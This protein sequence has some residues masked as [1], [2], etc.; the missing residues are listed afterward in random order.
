MADKD[1][2]AEKLK[3]AA[4]KQGVPAVPDTELPEDPSEAKKQLREQKNQL[5]KDEKARKKEARLRAKSISKQEAEISEDEDP[6]GIS[7]VLVTV[8]IILIWLAII[9]LLIKLDVGGFGSNVLAPLIKDVPVINKILPADSIETESGDN[10]DYG[11]YTNLKDA[12]SEIKELQQELAQAQADS[13]S[14]ATEVES[15]QAEVTR[16]K[17]F[18]DSQVEFEKVKTDFYNE[19]VY[20]DNAPDIDEY[21]KYYESIDPDTA[22]ELYKEVVQQEATDKKMDDYVKAYSSMKP[23][24]AAGIFEKMDDNLDLA[25]SI[26]TAMDS[27]SRGKIL[28]AMDPDI[29]AKIT[30]LMEPESK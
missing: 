21:R 13:T 7:V 30:K 28:G 15:L 18:E 8:L 5:K 1:S 9:C 12:V 11:G 17:T 16:L 2:K 26:L 25:A 24:E 4:D 19:V 6:G 3:T 27:D 10:F 20:A 29:A 23:K 22:A 14:D